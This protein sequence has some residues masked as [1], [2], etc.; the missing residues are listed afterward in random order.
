VYLWD[1]SPSDL[2]DPMA[3]MSDLWDPTIYVSDLWDLTTPFSI[4]I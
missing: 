2:W 4:S 1:P 3:Y